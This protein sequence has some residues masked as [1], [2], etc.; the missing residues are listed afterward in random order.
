MLVE[1]TPDYLAALHFCIERDIWDVLPI[2]MLGRQTGRGQIHPDALALLKG[3]R[4][5]IYPHADKDGG[6]MEAAS[7]WAAQLAAIG[8]V[9]DA[10]T[11]DGLTKRDGSL[12][13]DLNDTAL[14][15]PDQ[16]HELESILP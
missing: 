5:R 2:A 16:Q 7:T 1:G 13:N 6:G 9:V 10:F 4:V 12:V 15:H 14:I 11:F 8:C 3:Q